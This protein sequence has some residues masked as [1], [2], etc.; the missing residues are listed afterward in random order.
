MVYR[1]KEEG[2]R[3][4]EGM[5]TQNTFPQL[6]MVALDRCYRTEDLELRV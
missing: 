4:E 5:K 3:N 2:Q 6:D 1:T